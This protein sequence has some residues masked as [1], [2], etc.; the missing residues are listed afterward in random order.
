MNKDQTLKF[1]CFFLIIASFVYVFVGLT[2]VNL[3]GYYPVLHKWSVAPIK[4][5]ISMGF[6]SRVAFALIFSLIVTYATILFTRNNQVKEETLIGFTK[7]AVIFGILFFIAE[8]WHKWG[9]EKMK[10][11]TQ[12]FLNYEFWFFLIVSIIALS[13]VC[14]TTG[15]C[16]R[17]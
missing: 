13:A 1:I 3:P 14:I 6:Y 7:A 15:N 12:N 4:D 9:I 16:R 10:L 5:A 11:D 8:E 17:K 2:G